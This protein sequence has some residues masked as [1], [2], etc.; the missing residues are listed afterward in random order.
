M[1]ELAQPQLQKWA[2]CSTAVFPKMFMFREKLSQVPP[3]PNDY[4]VMAPPPRT[5]PPP[6]FATVYNK[7]TGGGGG[8][9]V[10]I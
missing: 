7:L 3:L 8:W 5:A 2:G 1:L 9:C 10:Y 6:H 4:N